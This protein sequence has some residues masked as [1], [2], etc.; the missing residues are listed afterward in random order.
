MTWLV[1]TP[2]LEVSTPATASW[3]LVT[4]HL[5]R[6]HCTRGIQY[7]DLFLGLWDLSFRW[8]HLSEIT[9]SLGQTQSS[10]LQVGKTVHNVGGLACILGLPNFHNQSLQ[11]RNVLVERPRVHSTSSWKNWRILQLN[12]SEIGTTNALQCQVPVWWD[13]TISPRTSKNDLI[14]VRRW[15]GTWK[16]VPMSN[17]CSEWIC[18]RGEGLV[19][20]IVNI[21]PT[22]SLLLLRCAAV[23]RAPTIL[24]IDRF[25]PDSRFHESGKKHGKLSMHVFVSNTAVAWSLSWCFE[26]F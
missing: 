13:H 19:H 1:P 15:R 3:T 14:I 18:R 10:P 2:D 21:P 16:G 26:I 12:R 20:H 7:P 4:F 8:L 9:L 6:S 25:V 11:Q 17:W 5:L 23:R 22:L 24:P